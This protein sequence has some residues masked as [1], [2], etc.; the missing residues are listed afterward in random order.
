MSL[1]Y[2]RYSPNSRLFFLQDVRNVYLFATHFTQ[3]QRLQIPASDPAGTGAAS[4]SISTI[5]FD[6]IQELLWV[7]NESVRSRICL[8]QI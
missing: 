2:H 6:S 4:G 8:M 7:G 1:K 5:A 3:V